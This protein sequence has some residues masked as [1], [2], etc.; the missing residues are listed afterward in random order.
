MIFLLSL[1]FTLLLFPLFSFCSFLYFILAL[2]VLFLLFCFLFSFLSVWLS[3]NWL[4]HCISLTFY[5]ISFPFVL[6]CSNFS[7]FSLLLLYIVTIFSQSFSFHPIDYVLFP[8]WYY[9]YV[10]CG[11]FFC[12]TKGQVVSDSFL[13]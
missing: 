3:V 5:C 4:S 2:F 11:V 13:L 1:F 9:H 12:P 8:S 7:L 10:F 6:F